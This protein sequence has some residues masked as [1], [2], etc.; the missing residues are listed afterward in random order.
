MK[1]FFE[2]AQGVQ[3]GKAKKEPPFLYHVPPF[4]DEV[5]D[6]SIGITDILQ[7]WKYIPFDQCMLQLGEIFHL[8]PI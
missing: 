2:N 7:G 5:V 4:V 6:V 3:H 8:A 1:R